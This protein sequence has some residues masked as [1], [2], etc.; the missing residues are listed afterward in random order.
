MSDEVPNEDAELIQ[1]VLAGDREAYGILV[2]RYQD[3]LFNTLVRVLGSRDDAQ[4]VVQ[5][6]FVQAFVKLETFRAAS[7]FYTWL[8]RIAMN[9]ALSH[10]RR[11]RPVASIE[12]VKEGAGEEPVDQ[13]RGPEDRLMD[14]ERVAAVQSALVGLGDEHRQ[15]LVL[16]EMEGCSYET[17]AEILQLPIGTVRSRLFRA[18]LVLKEQLKN[19]FDDEADRSLR[20]GQSLDS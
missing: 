13:E 2:E 16:R 14:R 1:A 11:R 19:I 12:A 17:I 7:R 15:I 18:R 9:L 5:D 4:D 10:R 8:Y 20:E 6:A 3:R